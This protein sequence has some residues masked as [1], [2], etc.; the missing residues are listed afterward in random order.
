MK[1]I[2]YVVMEVA[3]ILQWAENWSYR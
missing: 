1:R 3:T 2:Y